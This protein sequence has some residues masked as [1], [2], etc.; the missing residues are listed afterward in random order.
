M[1]YLFS[2]A[3]MQAIDALLSARSPLLAFDFDGTLA[4]IVGHPDDV[5][6]PQAVREALRGLAALRTVA[7]ITGRSVDDVRPRLGF[8]PAYLV[9]NHG[10][11]GLPGAQADRRHLLDSVRKHLCRQM[12][13]LQ[14]HGVM[15]EDKGGSLALHYR[16]AGDRPGA[17]RAIESVLAGL[18]S[19]LE[20]FGGKLVMNVVPAASP[21]KGDA[22]MHL[23][24]HAGC[25]T[26]LFIGDDV[27]DEAVFRI[28]A[29]DWVTVRIGCDA[30]DTK[31][32]FVLR[33]SDQVVELLERMRKRLDGGD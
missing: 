8:E 21:D 32:K 27:N 31:A 11:E 16:L 25:D 26:V 33:S 5:S 30:T 18:D 10:A 3:G 12:R 29:P 6:V 22:V 15:V 28:A 24:A 4:P 9:G 17:L 1:S 19:S 13:L 7:V 23:V 2:P 20:T 14:R